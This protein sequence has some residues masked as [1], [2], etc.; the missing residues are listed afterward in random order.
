MTY[1]QSASTIHHQ[2]PANAFEILRDCRAHYLDSLVR[3]ARDAGVVMPEAL[4]ALRMGAGGYYDEIL[5]GARRSGFEMARGLT[6]SRITLVG[7]DDL[8]LEISLDELSVR[9]MEGCNPHLWPV[10]QRFVTLLNRPDLDKSDNPV[11]PEGLCVGLTDM[12]AEL[13]APPD[14]ARALVAR[15]E[16]HLTV[17][18]P[19]FYQGLNTFLADQGV[20]ATQPRMI[21]RLEPGRNNTAPTQALGAPFSGSGAALSSPASPTGTTPPLPATALSQKPAAVAAATITGTAS[22]ELAAAQRQSI[23][24]R[25][26]QFEKLPRTAEMAALERSN[27]LSSLIPGLFSSNS[28][29]L[30]PPPRA[31]SPAEL[32]IPENTREAVVTNALLRIFG[33]VTNHPTLA[34]AVKTSIESLHLPFIKAALADVRAVDADLPGLRDLIN[35]LVRAA[36]GLPRHVASDHP[37]CQQLSRPLTQLHQSYGATA[38]ILPNTIQMASA[39]VIERDLNV[40]NAAQPYAELM[41][42]LERGDMAERRSR[43]VVRHYV[44]RGLPMPIGQFLDTFWQQVLTSVWLESGESSPAWQQHVEVIETLLWSIAP[45]LGTDDRKRLAGMLPAMLTCL[46]AGMARINMPATARETFLDACFTLQTASL[47]AALDKNGSVASLPAQ[48]FPPAANDQAGLR[49]NSVG[50]QTGEIKLGSRVLKTLE[51]PGASEFTTTSG[52]IAS[53]NVG[54]WLEFTFDGKDP[55]CGRLCLI[56]PGSRR[57]LLFNPDWGFAVSIHPVVLDRQFREGKA[58]LTGNRPLF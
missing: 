52:R 13:N 2:P 23:L 37:F 11:G 46:N 16:E 17:E 26:E 20:E 58:G 28:I 53:C 48:Y 25:L 39:L 50:V 7:E 44:S 30:E 12:C 22:T 47:R 5:A 33:S 4:E 40:A 41:Q 57:A 36:L 8:E 1:K 32:G 3:I 45:K 51:I 54:D 18:L 34:E 21:S 35:R 19:K 31:L 56:T 14:S 9:L 6:S 38:N 27:S 49:L 29:A 10:Y 43:Q 24:E 42:H 15:L 55:L